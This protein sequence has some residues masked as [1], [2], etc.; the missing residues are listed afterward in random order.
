[1]GRR[2]AGFTLI[3]ILIA[4]ALIGILSAVA[5][6][7]YGSYVL[8]GRLT[9]AFTTLSAIQP[10]AEEYWS[11][12]RTYVGLPVPASSDYFDYALS[13]D[14]SDSS[15]KLTATGKGMAGQFVFTIDQNGSRAT[16]GV[17]SGWTG[18]SSCW[19]DRKGGKCVQ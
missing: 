14:T 8:R 7:A 10:K 4:L 17:P 6:P 5:I 9:E 12:N 1:M 16:T 13:A 19:V 11:N 2:E 18:S 15:F 3:E